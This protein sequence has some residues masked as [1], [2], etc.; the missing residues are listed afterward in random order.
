[1]RSKITKVLI[2]EQDDRRV[3][4]RPEKIVDDVESC[5]KPFELSKK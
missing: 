5:R 4:L 3:S 2:I 1:M